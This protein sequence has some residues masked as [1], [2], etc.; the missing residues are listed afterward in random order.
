MRFTLWA[1]GWT[2]LTYRYPAELYNLPVKSL[3]ILMW[4]TLII[5]LWQDIKEINRK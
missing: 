3:L 1:L 2:F 4:G 5:C